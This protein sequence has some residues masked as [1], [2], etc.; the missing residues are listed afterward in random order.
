[1]PRAIYFTC[2]IL[3]D[4]FEVSTKQQEQE[5]AEILAKYFKPHEDV[6]A[7]PDAIK[8]IPFF[9]EDSRYQ[10]DRSN[11][12]WLEELRQ[13]Y[14]DKDDV[15]YGRLLYRYSERYGIDEEM[16]R[17]NIRKAFGPD[18]LAEFEVKFHSQEEADNL[19]EF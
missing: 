8:K 10:L 16:L 9:L 17:E 18:R 19:A 15:G 6:D 3:P 1:M 4:Q 7:S 5:I 12:R 13:V 11:D 2:I 14:L